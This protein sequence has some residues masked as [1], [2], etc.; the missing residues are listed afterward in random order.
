MA[1]R[2]HADGFDGFNFREAL[3]YGMACRSFYLDC[4]NYIISVLGNVKSPL[5]P[6]E[7]IVTN[8]DFLV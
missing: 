5:I 4:K 6:N 1:K 3:T 7:P 8:M 2:F